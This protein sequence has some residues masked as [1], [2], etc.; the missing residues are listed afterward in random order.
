M[1]ITISPG[2]TV[3]PVTAEQA[4]YFHHRLGH[5]HHMYMVMAANWRTNELD[6]ESGWF[7]ELT[8]DELESE[9]FLD[10]FAEATL[11]LWSRHGHEEPQST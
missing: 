7:E 6:A 8:A 3:I 5:L 10:D 1:N 2:Q 11:Q 4:L 9:D